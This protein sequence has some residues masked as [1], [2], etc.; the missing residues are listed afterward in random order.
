MISLWWASPNFSLVLSG[1][2]TAH[3][4]TSVILLCSNLFLPKNPWNQVHFQNKCLPN[5]GFFIPPRKQKQ[6]NHRLSTLLCSGYWVDCKNRDCTFLVEIYLSVTPGTINSC[7]KRGKK[8][9]GLFSAGSN[10]NYLGY[11]YDHVRWPAPIIAPRF[12]YLILQ[13]L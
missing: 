11:D 2:P 5:N 12:I 8:I 7:L 10:F 13:W 6:G 1:H 4:I 3:N 9:N